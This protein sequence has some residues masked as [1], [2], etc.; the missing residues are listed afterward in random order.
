[1]GDMWTA[2]PGVVFLDVIPCAVQ[3]A[4]LETFEGLSFQKFN[5][6]DAH[7]LL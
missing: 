3:D 6:L 4:D 2:V 1:M 7:F 5:S